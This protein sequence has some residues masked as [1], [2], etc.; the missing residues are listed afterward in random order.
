MRFVEFVN[1]IIS[2]YEG[3]VVSDVQGDP[4]KCTVAFGSGLHGWTFTIRQFSERYAKKFGVNKNK[5]MTKLWGDVFFNPKTKHWTSKDRDQDGKPL[6]RA[7]NMFFLDPVFKLFDAIMN[8]KKNQIPI[9]LEKLK[10]VLKAEKKR[11]GRQ[12][13]VKSRYEKNFN[14]CRCFIRNNCDTFTISCNCTGL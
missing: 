5:M 13:I 2:T 11:S 7:F 14:C 1:V 10:N 8:Y 12:G 6:E 9:L 3:K 4:S